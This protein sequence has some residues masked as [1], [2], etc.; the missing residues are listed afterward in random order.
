MNLSQACEIAGVP[1]PTATGWIKADLIRVKDYVGRRGVPLKLGPKH[2]RELV[3]LNKLRDVLPF[4]ALRDAARYLRS[5][6]ANPYSTGTFAAVSGPPGKRRLVKLC[7]TGEIVELL[8]KRRGQQL[9]FLD[10]APPEA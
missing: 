2:V 6:G 4:G 1:Q 8:G 7:D 5:L 10:V 9:L 3:I